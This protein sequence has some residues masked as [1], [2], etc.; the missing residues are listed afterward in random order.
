MELEQEPAGHP[1]TSDETLVP[2]D[3]R[4][5]GLR[6]AIAA[7]HRRYVVRATVDSFLIFNPNGK[8]IIVRCI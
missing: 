4:L 8:N 1:A 5:L 3:N 2:Q 6:R 7:K